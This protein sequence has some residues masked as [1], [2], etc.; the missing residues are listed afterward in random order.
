V[1]KKNLARAAEYFRLA[2]EQG[3]AIGQVNFGFCLKNGDGVEKDV[4]RAVEYFRLSA[5]QGNVEAQF[6][7]ATC[8]EKGTGIKT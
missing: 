2:A 4:V 5:D 6:H 3:N 8:L 7:F 1:L